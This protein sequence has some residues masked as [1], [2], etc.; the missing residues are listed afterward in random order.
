MKS[1]LTK[2]HLTAERTRSLQALGVAAQ[3]LLAEAGAELEEGE[4]RLCPHPHGAGVA[5]GGA[6]GG[7]AVG[8]GGLGGGLGVVRG[9][10]GAQHVLLAKDRRGEVEAG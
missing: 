6:E 2:G 7:E 5:G 8:G 3:A 9:E 4:V 10:A 1:L